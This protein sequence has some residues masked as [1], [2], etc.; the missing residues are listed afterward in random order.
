M[1]L[2]HLYV[3]RILD[4]VHATIGLRQ[5]LF[6]VATIR[7]VEGVTDTHRNRDRVATN[8]LAHLADNCFKPMDHFCGRIL[9]ETRRND[10]EFISTHSR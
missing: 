1:A 4:V 3:M 8:N 6:G 5:N 7:R 9:M 2:R 10:Y